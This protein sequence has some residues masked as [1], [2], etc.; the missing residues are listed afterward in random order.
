MTLLAAFQIL[1]F[2]YSEQTDI[3]V[4]TS[5]AG[6]RHTELEGLIGCFLNMLVLRTDLSGEPSF[7]ELLKRVKAVTLEAYAHQ[8]VPFEKL[9]E[10]LQPERD[11]RRSPLFQ[12]MLVFHNAPQSELQLGAARLQILDIQN[13]SAKF[14]LTLFLADGANGLQ[15]VLH[16]NSSLFDAEAIARMIEDYQ[17]VLKSAV[18]APQQ[19]ITALS[20]TSEDE[21][22]QLLSDWNEESPQLIGQKSTIA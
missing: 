4:G 8:D 19:P 10:T 11:L 3:A 13:T 22:Q 21:Q 5:I 15:G 12:V 6:R 7:A 14:D 9:V 17:M 2:S 18:A 1:L 20:L 16:Y